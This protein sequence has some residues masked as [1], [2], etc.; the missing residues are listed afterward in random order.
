MGIYNVNSSNL[1]RADIVDKPCIN[2]LSRVI[3]LKRLSSTSKPSRTSLS[4]LSYP[5]IDPFNLSKT[6]FYSQN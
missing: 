3:T 1:P 4:L 6:Q 5:A 2:A